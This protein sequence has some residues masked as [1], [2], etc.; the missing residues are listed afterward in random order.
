MGRIGH[1][2]SQPTR[3]SFF[4]LLPLHPAEDTLLQ[5]T[6]TESKWHGQWSWYE[7]VIVGCSGLSDS[8]CIILWHQ[9]QMLRGPCTYLNDRG[10]WFKSPN[11]LQMSLL[12]C[13]VFNSTPVP[14]AVRS[15]FRLWYHSWRPWRWDTASIKTPTTTWSTLLMSHRRYTTCYS[16]LEWWWVETRGHLQNLTGLKLY[17]KSI[18]F[19]KHI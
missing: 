3:W 12:A 11:S 18:T 7:Y 6:A 17:L 9:F 10:S 19:S 13:I 2:S 14:S 15:P 1:S 16:R 4:L 5:V 8:Q